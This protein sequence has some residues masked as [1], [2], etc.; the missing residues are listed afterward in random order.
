MW[1]ARTSG[2]WELRPEC[3][4]ACS[5][6]SNG[7]TVVRRVAGGARL[8]AAD[9]E[10]VDDLPE[11]CHGPERFLRELFVIIA[12]DRSAEHNVSAM[13]LDP[14]LAGSGRPGFGKR[15]RDLLVNAVRSDFEA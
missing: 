11:S 7:A 13:N 5:S 4:P 14:H 6:A 8:L 12:A 15:R 1:L 2:A 3:V 10:L 9:F